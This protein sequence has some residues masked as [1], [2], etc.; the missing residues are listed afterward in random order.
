[1]VSIGC[2]GRLCGTASCAESREQE[3][4]VGGGLARLLSVRVQRVSEEKVVWR[5]RCG[6][7]G[8]WAGVA[9]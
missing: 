7:Q 6:A 1:M 5:C 9:S 2:R 8:G 3:E 4:N